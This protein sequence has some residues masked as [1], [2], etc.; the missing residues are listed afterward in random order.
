MLSFS[1]D[2]WQQIFNWITCI[3][4]IQFSGELNPTEFFSSFVVTYSRL[5]STRTNLVKP[6]KYILNEIKSYYSFPSY[7]SEFWL[8]LVLFV[9]FGRFQNELAIFSYSTISGITK[10][11][12]CKIIKFNDYCILTQSRRIHSFWLLALKFIFTFFILSKKLISFHWKKKI[13]SALNTLK[14]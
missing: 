13:E 3:C 6:L 11:Q 8:V 2:P 7:R 14:V 10:I 4:S 1:L 5:L 9:C 12:F